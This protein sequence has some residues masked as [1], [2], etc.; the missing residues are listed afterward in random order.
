MYRKRNRWFAGSFVLFRK[1]FERYTLNKTFYIKKLYKSFSKFYAGVLGVCI[2]IFITDH[3]IR[4]ENGSVAFTVLF[5]STHPFTVSPS[6]GAEEGD[7]FAVQFDVHSWNIGSNSD[8][9]LLGTHGRTSK[10]DSV[11]GIH[12]GT[13]KFRGSQ[14]RGLSA[15]Q[16]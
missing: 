10:S 13:V 5:P 1:H 2:R 4:R 14:Y 16:K 12:H 8:S 7:F 15:G 6:V 3:G 9:S 11:V